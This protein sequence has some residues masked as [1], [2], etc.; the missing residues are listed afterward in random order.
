MTRIPAGAPNGVDGHGLTMVWRWFRRPL[1]SLSARL[2]RV[3]VVIVAI[4]GL[5]ALV[6]PLLIAG[7]WLP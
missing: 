2:T 4:Y 3:G 5:L 1:P 6:M 7:G